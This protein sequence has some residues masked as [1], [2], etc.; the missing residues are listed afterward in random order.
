MRD[1]ILIDIINML[2]FIRTGFDFIKG[3]YKQ[4]KEQ[5]IKILP[6]KMKLVDVF[7]LLYKIILIKI[8]VVI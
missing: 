3:M 5:N 6:T 4:S 7:M 8:H 1:R 2:L